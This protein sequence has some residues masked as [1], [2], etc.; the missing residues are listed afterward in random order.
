M[1]LA[2]TGMYLLLH[3]KH[4]YCR[5]Y[6]LIGK[7]LILHV[8]VSGSSP[9]ISNGTIILPNIFGKCR[10]YIDGWPYKL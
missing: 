6:G 5:G 8:F 4:G 9:D 1:C 3:V 10:T 7:T 2:I